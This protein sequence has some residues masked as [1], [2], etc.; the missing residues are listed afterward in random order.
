MTE[1]AFFTMLRSALRRKTIY[2]KPIQTVKLNARVPNDTKSRHKWLY[3]C[4]SCKKK[5]PND[6]V[7]VN[8]LD[9]PISLKSYSDLPNFCEKLFCEDISKYEVLC[10]PCHRKHTNS[11]LY[12]K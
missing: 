8:H 2:W 4:N 1:A 3:V 5:F 9:P 11:V 10:K 7:E 6:D 12:D